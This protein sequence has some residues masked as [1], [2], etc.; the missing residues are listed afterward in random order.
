M[1]QKTVT[2]F[3]SSSPPESSDEYRVA[4]ELGKSLALAGFTVC[5]GGFGGIM[6]ASARGAK[7]AGGATVGITVSVFPRKANA[8]I[9]KEM[10]FPDLTQRLVKLVE[11]GDAYVIL[12]GG[13]G[14]LLEFA[15]VWEFINKGLMQ[16]K[17]IVVLGTFWDGVIDTLKKELIWEGLGDCTKHIRQVKTVNEC[18][19]Y[20]R[21][22]LR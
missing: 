9:E 11:L 16:E 14:T 3:G 1:T 4:F 18:V 2:I 22:M 8:W 19:E 17:P 10:R 15:Y 12:K 13:T 21:S 20:L 7:E 5:N 6:E